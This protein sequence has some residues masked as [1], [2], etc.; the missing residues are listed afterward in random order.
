MIESAIIYVVGA[1]IAHPSLLIL[2]FG[3]IGFVWY[4]EC[5]A[6]SGRPK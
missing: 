4:L 6:M 3:C 2:P 5:R 1:F